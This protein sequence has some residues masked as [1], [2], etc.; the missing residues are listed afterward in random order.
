MHLM[1]WHAERWL[2][3]GSRRHNK[4]KLIRAIRQ[5][6]FYATTVHRTLVIL[7]VLFV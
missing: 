5:I 6:I 7:H 2:I 3:L 1:I 4:R